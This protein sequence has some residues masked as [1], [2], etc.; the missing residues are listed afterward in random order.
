[1][2]ENKYDGKVSL[3]SMAKWNAHEKDCRERAN[4]LP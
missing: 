3:K 2:K 1:M 4:G